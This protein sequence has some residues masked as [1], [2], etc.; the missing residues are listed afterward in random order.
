MSPVTSLWQ[1][2]EQTAQAREREPALALAGEEVSFGALRADAIRCAGWLHRAG[3]RQ[4]DVVALQLPNSPEF[5]I[6]YLAV[7][8]LGAVL[9][10]LHMPYRA[11][12]V[13]AVEL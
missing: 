12:E 9:C 6:S 5:V 13:E 7:C 2:L 1:G 11:A 10:T 8:R 3:L 4:G